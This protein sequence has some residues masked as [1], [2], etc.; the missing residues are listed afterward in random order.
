MFRP[1]RLVKL[2]CFFP[3]KSAHA[4]ADRVQQL[5]VAHLF[6]I[7]EEKK[8]LKPLGARR[9]DEV[10]ELLEKLEARIESIER[11]GGKDI[12]EILFGPRYAA[13]EAETRSEADAVKEAR[14]LLAEL[15]KS[16]AVRRKNAGEIKKRH[17]R[18]LLAAAERLRDLR[19]RE[20]ALQKFG[21]TGF[22]ASFGCFVKE[23]DAE[24]MKTA[25]DAAAN[26]KCAF[27]VKRAGNDAPTLLENPWAIK[28]FEV[29]TENYGLP[30]Y[31]GFDPTL[32]LA[33][34]FTLLFG[35]MFPDMG[36][37]AALAFLS[38]AAYFMTR[39]APRNVRNVNIIL[40]YCGLSAAFFG[41]LFGEFFGLE[42]KPFLFNPAGNIVGILAVSAMIG[43]VHLSAAML[44]NIAKEKLRYISGILLLWSVPLF[45]YTRNAAFIALFAGAAAALFYSRKLY[46]AKDIITLF[47]RV[48]SY[49]RVGVLGVAHVTIS[50]LF[51]SFVSLLPKDIPGL[52]LGAL[53]IAAGVLFSFAIG[54]VVVFIQ[55]LRLEW[56]E[57]FGEF[58]F[59]GKPFRAFSRKREYLL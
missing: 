20:D 29:L 15:D 23:S 8:R 53:L 46:A 13:I 21:S 19:E 48:I 18:R 35:M 55:S 11:F 5:G 49:L 6:D 27:E 37:G 4:V 17:Y 2:Y 47:M 39:K 14:T 3:K 50:S 10:R 41:F 40:F 12:S 43:I 42:V 34:T 54:V 24:R 9:S 36:Y 31:N 7:K 58:E 52:V 30:P 32:L 45:A 22:T 33:V 25:V 1:A 51:V 44:S 28:P 57:F 26:R 38:A 56:L 16:G 59:G